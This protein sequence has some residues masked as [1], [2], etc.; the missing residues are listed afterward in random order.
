MKM[1]FYKIT[2]ILLAFILS[3]AA[4]A[5]KNLLYVGITDNTVDTKLIEYLDPQGYMITF[6]TEDDYKVAPYDD[7]A[8]Y[9]AYDAIF[10]SEV[11]GSGSTVNFKTA[12]FPIPCVTTEGY[13][14][15]S[16]K[17][18]LITDNDNHFKQLSSADVTT[19]VTN[20]VMLDAPN[21]I[22]GHYDA[23]YILPWSTVDVS[24]NNQIG[25]T[26]FKLN[27]NIPD[28]IPLALNAQDVMAEFPT[29][30]AIPEGSSLI[31]D[32]AVTLP[33][34]VFIGAISSGLG[35]YATVGF[36]ELVMNSLKWVTQDYVAGVGDLKSYDLNVWPNPTNGIVNISLTSPVS[37]N[38]K[39]NIYDI[40]G[41]LMETI[42]S[43]YLLAGTNTIN[44]DMS[45]HVAANYIFEVITKDD[46]LRG[47]ICKN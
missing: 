43:D 37:G 1:N 30:W 21:W 24:V 18:A 33:R 26:G 38:V 6:V 15:R 47:K 36:N 35:D 44:I 12:G 14:V 2:L 32:G 4:I 9:A 8:T 34:I 11:V 10:I 28:A 3:N 45:D 5:Q 27:E 31:S 25:V 46:I 17:W 16:D 19:D 39:V 40:S 29:M 23:N 13:A 20:M 7:A 22:S 42:N 41:R